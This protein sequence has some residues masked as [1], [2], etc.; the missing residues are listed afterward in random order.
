[1]LGL[2]PWPTPP[3]Q[4]H[5]VGGAFGGRERGE[6]VLSTSLWP[7]THRIGSGAAVCISKLEA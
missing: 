5:T 6:R 1:M 4:G 7:G 2:H 3:H